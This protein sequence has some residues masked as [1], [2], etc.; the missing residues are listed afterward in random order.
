MNVGK[1][2]FHQNGRRK[3][4]PSVLHITAQKTS[5]MPDENFDWVFSQPL[6]Y[7]TIIL[8]Q[9]SRLPERGSLL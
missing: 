8:L 5:S 6:I 9:M 7:G 2:I 3:V 4:A 1:I